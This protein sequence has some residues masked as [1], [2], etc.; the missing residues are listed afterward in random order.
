MTTDGQNNTEDAAIDLFEAAVAYL[1]ALRDKG[2]AA[3]K[4]LDKTTILRQILPYADGLGDLLRLDAGD[5]HKIFAGYQ[6]GY[7]YDRLRQCRK[8]L[9]LYRQEKQG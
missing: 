4:L 9:E 2:S 8:L 3:Q 7:L 1:V 5:F 6:E